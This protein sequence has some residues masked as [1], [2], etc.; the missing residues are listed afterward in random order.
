[1]DLKKISEEIVDGLLQGQPSSQI[2]L[3]CQILAREAENEWFGILIESEQKGYRIAVA[4][5]KFREVE[6]HIK[7]YIYQGFSRREE[8]VEIPADLYPIYGNAADRR[9]LDVYLNWKVG[10]PLCK[11]EEDCSRCKSDE[12]VYP[13]DPIFLA[14]LRA[15]VPRV[16]NAERAEYYVAVGNLRNVIE[17]FK[18]CL[19]DF[20]L[21]LL[22]EI[23]WSA[24]IAEGQNKER[25][26]ALVEELRNALDKRD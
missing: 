8:I 16:K 7:V 22:K 2:L 12:L 21:K 19:L 23:D 3:K 13:M 15:T 1:M 18:A 17:T 11:L 9:M 25:F 4:A 14:V 20:F 10:L 24:G 26:D 5:E 6:T